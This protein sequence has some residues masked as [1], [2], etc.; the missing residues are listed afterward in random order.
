M[1]DRIQN[2]ID[3]I[4]EEEEVLSVFLSTLTE[5]KEFIV[6]NDIEK[7]D[8]T[9]RREEELI[10]K[11][12]ELEEGRMAVVKSIASLAG[13]K[14][15]ELTLTRLIEMNLG[16]VSDELKALKKTLASLVDK[17]KRANRVNQ[18]LIKRSLSFIQKN[19]SWFIDDDNLNLI[20]A[21]SGL[22]RVSGG[23]NVLV[24]RVL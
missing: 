21:P 24:D 10:L 4:R 16:E 17:I 12:K 15:D 3:L 8:S 20:Y 2:L 9:V 22:Q 23:E 14:E 7:F 18:Y 1:D 6:Q 5:Q 13:S 11:I 19:I